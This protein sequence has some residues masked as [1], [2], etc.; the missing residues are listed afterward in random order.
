MTDEGSE[1]TAEQLLFEELHDRARKLLTKQWYD[2]REGRVMSRLEERPHLVMM[3][4][5]LL[6]CQKRFV[7]DNLD[8]TVKDLLDERA[9][10]KNPLHYYGLSQGNFL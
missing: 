9:Y 8:A 1:P 3:Y 7:E 2:T 6:A 4:A 10:Y 5:A